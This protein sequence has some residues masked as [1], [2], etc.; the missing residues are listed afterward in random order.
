MMALFLWKP[1]LG[2]QEMSV[3]TTN[4]SVIH[5]AAVRIEARTIMNKESKPWFFNVV[6]RTFSNVLYYT[7]T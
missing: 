2:S 1:N 3:Q 7:S 4:K 6:H 5:S